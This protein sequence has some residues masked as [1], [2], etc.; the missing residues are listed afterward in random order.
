MQVIKVGGNELTDNSFLQGLAQ[1]VQQIQATTGQPVVI[2]HGGGRA[3]ADL[4]T[5]LGLSVKK[6]DGLRVTDVESLLVAEMALSGYSNKLIVKALLAEG[7]QAVGLSGVDGRLL[8]ARKKQHPTADLGLVGEIIAVNGT[9]LQ[10]LAS[11]GWTA[12]I[13]PISFSQNNITYNVNADE[14]ASAIAQALSASILS[15]V[16]NVPGVLQNGT[17][18]STLTIEQAESL[19]ATTVITDGM[20]PKVRAACTAVTQGVSQARIVNLAGLAGVGGTV[21]SM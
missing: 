4:Q 13:S 3:I 1:G 16:S 18:M 12:V 5:K 17:I 10:Q 15:L 8:T 6:V 19:I 7:I 11:G 20:I 14:A 9:L 21:F 2:V